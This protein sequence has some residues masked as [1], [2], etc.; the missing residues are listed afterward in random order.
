MAERCRLSERGSGKYTVVS[1]LS[2]PFGVV[3]SPF[4]LGA[5]LENHLSS[6]NLELA[7]KL[8]DDIYIDNVVPGTDTVRE[9]LTFYNGTKAI[10]FDA[11][12]N[13]R[14]WTSSNDEV[15]M[16]IP[17]ADKS[18]NEIVKVLRHIWNVVDDSLSLK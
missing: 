12:M 6:H 5:T 17:P 18:D 9:A 7:N 13:H 8:K 4:L 3:S 15:R 10:F 1:F 11:S 14:E 2:V 16:F